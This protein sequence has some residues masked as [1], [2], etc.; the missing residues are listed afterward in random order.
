MNRFFGAFLLSAWCIV[1]QAQV[2]EEVVGMTQ[3]V[4]PQPQF[5]TAA[6]D[7]TINLPM[8]D[9]FTQKSPFPKS[10]YWVDQ[11]AFINNTHGQNPL[12]TGFATLDGLNESGFPYDITDN[13]SDT[14][15]DVLTS[16][17]FDLTG[18]NN[19]YLSFFYQGGGLGEDPAADDSLI[20]DFWSPIDSAWETVWVKEGSAMTVFKPAIIAVDNPKWLTNGFRFRF[21]AYGAKN[22]AFDIWNID[23][24]YFADNRNVGDTIL[25][26]PAFTRQLPT[27]LRKNYRSV[28]WFH[29]NN[30]L[31]QDSLVTIYRRNGPTPNPPWSLTKNKHVLYYNGNAE[32]LS[33]GF[34]N[35]TDPHNVNLQ[36]PML[37]DGFNPAPPSDSFNISIDCILPGTKVEPF[38]ANDT[39]S[40]FQTFRNYYAFDDG[41]AERAY[42]VKNAF[43]ARIAMQIH[44]EKT[45]TLKGV[46]FRFAHAGDDAT[47][48]T[49]KIGIWENNAGVP[50]NEIYV[51]DS[52]YVPDYG[53]YHNSFMP[54]SLDT[55]GIFINGS[56]FIGIKQNTDQAIHI[57]LDINTTPKA[58]PVFYGDFFNWYESLAPGTIMVRPYFKYQPLNLSSDEHSLSLAPKVY[59]NPANDVLFIASESTFEYSLFD[60]T[61]RLAQNG[62]AK[63]SIDIQ[64]LDAGM[65]ILLL[66]DGH[67][68]FTQKIIVR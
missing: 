2:I 58:T 67:E 32:P 14:L 33:P 46:Y 12:S 20:V 68:Q 44:P 8:I 23:Y 18:E 43:G 37:I 42:G 55:S 3:R 45:D 41:T 9:E 65:Y 22:G 53:Y 10:A 39:L 56:V 52:N 21:G 49:F 6:I 25:S 54:F 24:V 35:S 7:D 61:G 5:K 64:S 29:F 48:Y 11:K 57:G 13:G 50:G 36:N 15:A 60:L 40:H 30:N 59:P 1:T 27:F 26:D 62:I 19:V 66:A 28:P 63:E 34:V 31:L 38:T 47:Q 16:R 4:L 51:T 17:Y